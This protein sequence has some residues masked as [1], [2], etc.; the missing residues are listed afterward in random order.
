MGSSWHR[1][2]LYRTKYEP[3]QMLYF[4]RTSNRWYQDC[5]Y[6]CVFPQQV[7]FP[8]TTPE[9]Y[10]QQAA[11]NII[12][13]LQAPPQNIPTLKYGSET[14]NAFIDITKILKRA[15]PPAIPHDNIPHNNITQHVENNNVFNV[16]PASEPRVH[17]VVLLN[18][19]E[20]KP[21][22]NP[23]LSPSLIPTPRLTPPTA[24]ILAPVS[25]PTISLKPTPSPT[26]YSPLVP[27]AYPT[28]PAQ[29]S[30][31]YMDLFANQIVDAIQNKH[32]AKPN[33]DPY[34]R[35]H[36][37]KISVSSRHNHFTR[38]RIKGFSA[39]SVIQMNAHGYQHYIANHI[40][41][42]ETGTQYTLDR[43]LVNKDGST[44]TDSLS[45]KFG[46]LAQGVGKNRPAK[47]QRHKY[48]DLHT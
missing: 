7:H 23:L 41:H 3:L 46:R 5:G 21:R 22:V 44:W 11:A 1:C 37:S 16:D 35:I 9:K 15:A 6:S 45:N 12:D 31:K 14:T 8:I 40:Y 4:L 18:N 30:E 13:I 25:V 32:A 29:I 43:L 48:H 28:T 19:N 2:M 17:T 36:H 33:L 10:L 47:S 42:D 34:T 26:T 24:R 38:S 20:S 39:Q 27:K